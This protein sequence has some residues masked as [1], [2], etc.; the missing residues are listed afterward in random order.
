[1]MLSDLPDE[2]LCCLF[3]CLDVADMRRAALVCRRWSELVF[4][5][6]RMDR[7]LLRPKPDE[8]SVLMRS[9]RNYRHIYLKFIDCT[10]PVFAEGMPEKILQ[11]FGLSITSL[12]IESGRRATRAMLRKL[13]LEVPNLQELSI[14]MDLPYSDTETTESFPVL[15][16]LKYLNL[17]PVEN[18]PLFRDT[19]NLPTN[20]PRLEHL[21]LNNEGAAFSN[22]LEYFSP[23][24]KVVTVYNATEQLFLLNFPQLRELN[25]AV[26]IRTT[27][28]LSL[29]FFSK[30]LLHSK[31][32]D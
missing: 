30:A 19:L 32:R 6:R 9:E 25:L 11:K 5:G 29:D 17:H 26:N 22:V 21:N 15:S 24:L 2:V 16:K 1:M 14:D 13:L 23:Q 8:C 18:M 4:S 7:V 27:P 12:R 10:A 3:D 31:A 28:L 20:S